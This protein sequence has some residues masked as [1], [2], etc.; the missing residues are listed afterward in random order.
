[1]DSYLVDRIAAQLLTPYWQ[2]R[3]KRSPEE[4]LS[5]F[6]DAYH[7]GLKL[8]PAAPIDPDALARPLRE[9][10]GERV[11]IN[12]DKEQRRATVRIEPV[13]GDT[14]KQDLGDVKE[15]TKQ[16]GTH[17]EVRSVDLS[18]AT[19]AMP[20]A[21]ETAMANA[22]RQKDEDRVAVRIDL[23]IPLQNLLLFGETALPLKPL[24]HGNVASY[25]DSANFDEQKCY[26]CNALHVIAYGQKSHAQ[27]RDDVYFACMAC[28]RLRLVA[29]GIPELVSYHI[30]LA[31]RLPPALAAVYA[32]TKAGRSREPSAR[33]FESPG[34]HYWLFANL[35][36]FL[37][38]TAVLPG[39]VL[40]WA[41]LSDDAF[42]NPVFQ[43]ARTLATL[44][45]AAYAISIG[46]VIRSKG[47][48][49]GGAATL[50]F[51]ALFATMIP[52]VVALTR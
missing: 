35:R 8:H 2:E 38:A 14:I 46:I 9:Q 6:A 41:W 20:A 15:L 16:L 36:H 52:V 7:F 43:G 22:Y 32:R 50:T 44:C 30:D 31:D 18:D 11:S 13:T 19:A 37:V 47:R 21:P 33:A 23:E 29:W 42:R 17:A 34:A 10:L 5:A 45:C 51:A 27:D 39:L 25:A 3:L 40:L 12:V 24:I 1:M 48:V 26:H 49:A 28:G 4:L